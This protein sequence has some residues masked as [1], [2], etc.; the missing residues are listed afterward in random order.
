VLACAGA[1]ALGQSGAGAADNRGASRSGS[2]SYGQSTSYD[3]TYGGAST[4]GY[5]ERGGANTYGDDYR[6]PFSGSGRYIYGIPANRSAPP[7]YGSEEQYGDWEGDDRNM[8]YGLRS[9]R[10]GR[11]GTAYELG[12][13]PGGGK[14]T[15]IGGGAPGPWF[16][17]TDSGFDAYST[18]DR[19]Q[20]LYGSRAGDFG[21][22]GT[23]DRNQELYGGRAA[24]D[25]YGGSDLYGSTGGAT[26]GG[27]SGD[28]RGYYSPYGTRSEDSL[29]LPRTSLYD[30][31]AR[32]GLGSATHDDRY[33]DRARGGYFDRYGS[34]YSADRYGR[35]RYFGDMTD[36]NESYRGAGRT[37]ED[38]YRD[39]TPTEGDTSQS[40]RTYERDSDT[41]R[42]RARGRY[43]TDSDNYRYRRATDRAS[44]RG[45]SGSAPKQP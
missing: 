21:T 36:D 22:Y 11:T 33:G 19:N 14:R 40:G 24:T 12:W 38:A 20:G 26:G 2:R 16:G 17:R 43:D 8:S 37:G 10:A 44:D 32:A 5:G 34:L 6:T 9:G 42:D 31:T 35:Y 28:A 39:R 7:R 30:G 18:R 25:R 23:R 29:Y 4:R 15:G 27:I 45:S 13:S 3:R 1:V 41:Y